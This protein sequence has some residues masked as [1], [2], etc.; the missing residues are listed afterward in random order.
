M[1]LSMF[2]CQIFCLAN[3][4]Y[5]KYI[6][7]VKDVI[8]RNAFAF[9]SLD[10][11]DGWDAIMGLQFENLV[12]ANLGSI[13]AMLGLGNAQILSAAP[14]RRQASRDGGRK[15]VQID[16]LIQTRRSICIVE[17]KRRREIGRDVIDEVAEKVRHLPRRDG[18]SVRTALVYDGRL[19]PIVEA[20]GYFDAIIPFRQL[21]NLP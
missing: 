16:L 9:G 6:E 1:A 19:A 5:L 13:V 21:L 2:T 11:L 4:F 14:Y 20:D 8:D 3:K 7:P 17:V 15:G 12:L 18:V 10:S